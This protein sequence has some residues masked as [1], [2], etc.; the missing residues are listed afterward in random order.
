M[1]L[2]LHCKS[3]GRSAVPSEGKAADM[4][5]LCSFDSVAVQEFN[6][7]YHNMDIYIYTHQVIWFLDYG[8]LF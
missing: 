5:Q 6:L 4:L 2:R 7:N 3:R 8:N 1:I